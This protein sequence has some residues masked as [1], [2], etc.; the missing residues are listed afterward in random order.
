MLKGKFKKVLDVVKTKITI[1][2]RRGN[3][4]LVEIMG[5]KRKLVI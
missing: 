4:H 3:K 5:K 1:N 2:I